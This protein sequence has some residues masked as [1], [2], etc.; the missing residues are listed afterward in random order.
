MKIDVDNDALVFTSGR[1][2]YAHR[3]VVGLTADLA[4]SHGWDGGIWPYGNDE[5]NLTKEDL[6]ELADYMVE[7][8]MAFRETVGEL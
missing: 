4:A 7:R 5:Q 2:A 3:G 8:W 6:L 1:T